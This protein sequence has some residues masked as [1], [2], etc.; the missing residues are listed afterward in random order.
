MTF[1]G[2]DELD[3]I[4]AQI[5]V[6]LVNAVYFHT[7]AIPNVRDCITR[8]T[9]R[10]FFY[11]E[12]NGFQIGIA[13]RTSKGI[14][15]T[16]DNRSRTYGHQQVTAGELNTA[17][18]GHHVFLACIIR[19][20]CIVHCFQLGCIIGKIQRNFATI[21]RHKLSAHCIQ[22]RRV[23]RFPFKEEVQGNS[24]SPNTT[25]LSITRNGRSVGNNVSDFICDKFGER[26]QIVQ[27]IP[28]SAIHDFVQTCRCRF[29]FCR[30]FGNPFFAFVDSFIYFV[31]FSKEVGIAKDCGFVVVTRSVIQTVFRMVFVIF[32]TVGVCILFTV[33]VAR[34]VGVVFGGLE[35][36]V[37]GCRIQ[38]GFVIQAVIRFRRCF[39]VRS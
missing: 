12:L 22:N 14:A 25:K 6:A 37:G 18:G 9:C 4:P 19:E 3:E 27:F 5:I 8:V 28:I 26:V 21:Y 29:I 33:K 7:L 39:V 11:G 32:F 34:G 38:H 17:V 2:D 36:T 16:Q 15:V 1:F 23:G 30:H 24:L 31:K 13:I 20:Q 10:D 35:R